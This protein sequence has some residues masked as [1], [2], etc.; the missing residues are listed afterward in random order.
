VTAVYVTV[1]L[2]LAGLLLGE[3]GRRRQRHS[4]VPPRGAQ[5]ASAAG[6]ALGVIHTI[7]ALAV[8]YNW[9]H[10]R[11]V[12]VAAH[13]AEAVYRVAWSG[14]LYANYL[15]LAWWAADMFWWLRSPSSFITRPLVIEWAWRLLVTTM[16]ANAAVVF[17]RPSARFAGALLLAGLFA[18]WR[19]GHHMAKAGDVTSG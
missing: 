4:G 19:A 11:A 13:R 18:A 6:V 1:W 15:F 3:L 7:L 12:T 16:V 10:A 9:D 14:S 8:V 2:S 5:L 17:A